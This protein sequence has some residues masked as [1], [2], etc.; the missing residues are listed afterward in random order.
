MD[1]SAGLIKQQPRSRC[2]TG[3]KKSADGKASTTKDTKVHKG[4]Q[5]RPLDPY[6]LA[7]L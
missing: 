2:F 6:F 4:T 1:S 5:E 7:S 3:L